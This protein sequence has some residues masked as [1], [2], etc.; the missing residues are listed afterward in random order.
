MNHI[1]H[2]IEKV[3]H[4]VSEVE[5]DVRINQIRAE[6]VELY[7]KAKAGNGTAADSD[8]YTAL[9]YELCELEDI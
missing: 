4:S 8:R 3:G 1:D 6:L 7:E 2:Q 5:P 9:V